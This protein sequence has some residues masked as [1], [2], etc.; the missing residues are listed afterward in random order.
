MVGKGSEPHIL[1]EQ[2]MLEFDSV[3]PFSPGAAAD[4]TV[5]NPAPYPVEFYSLE[6]DKSYLMEEEVSQRDV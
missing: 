2:T 3:L 1:F 6:F 5:I 4:V